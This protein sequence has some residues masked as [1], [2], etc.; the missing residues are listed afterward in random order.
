MTRITTPKKAYT[1]DYQ[2]AIDFARQQQHIF[3]TADEI[4]VE[5]DVQD[6]YVNMTEAE[7]H[8]VITTL[9]LFTLYELVAG[10]EYWGSRVV[11]EFPRPDIQRM[12]SC[13][14]FFE[15]NVHAPFYAKLNEAL[16]LDTDTFYTDYIND[17][18]LKSR[19]EFIDNIVNNS[20][21]TASVGT[22]SLVEGVILYSS[23]AFLKHFQT[24]GKNKLN[25][26]V[27]GINFSLNDEALHSEAGAW[28]YRTLCEESNLPYHDDVIVKAS[29]IIYEHECAIIDKIFEKGNIKGITDHQLKCFVQSRINLC[30]RNLGMDN[31]YEV[32]YNPIQ[33]WFYKNAN[34]VKLH[35]FFSRTGNAYNR[36]WTESKFIW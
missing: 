21:L 13:F 7:K 11:K 19:M 22:F 34:S 3:W 36:N 33:D 1:F 32:K 28:L 23:F 15:L 10:N 9:K 6:I 27:A 5:K 4:D 25:N 26:V 12:A 14:S 35:D 8:G 30:L 2:E 29:G 20:Y 18:I 17:P 16:G 24:M 31:I